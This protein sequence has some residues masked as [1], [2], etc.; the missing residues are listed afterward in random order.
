MNLYHCMIELKRD[1]QALAFASA[2]EHWL[3]GL[4]AR[5]LIGEW[6]L[7]RRKFGL[8]SAQH[9]DMILTIEVEDMA[10]LESAFRSLADAGSPADQK[11]YDLMH[12]MIGQLAVGL[13]RPYPDPTQRESVALV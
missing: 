3:S 6:K 5:G 10:Q 4:A 11:Y 7:F 9:S 13:Y 1:A 12:D 2:T 8:A